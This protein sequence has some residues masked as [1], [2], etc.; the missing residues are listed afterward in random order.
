MDLVACPCLLHCRQWAAERITEDPAYFRRLQN[1]QAPQWLWIGC[2]DSRVPVRLHCS[3]LAQHWFDFKMPRLAL[4]PPCATPD[5]ATGKCCH[6]PE[7]R[8][9]ESLGHAVSMVH[10]RRLIYGWACAEHHV[11]VGYVHAG[12]C[13]AQCWKPGA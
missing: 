4:L 2:A 13:A 11:C 6:R 7:A 12:L 8:R 10:A 1:I 5:A 9:G 3:P